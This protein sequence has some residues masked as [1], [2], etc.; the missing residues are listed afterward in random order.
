[1]KFTPEGGSVRIAGRSLHQA[2]VLS[3]TKNLRV[4]SES[5]FDRPLTENYLQISV[6]D[7]GIGLEKEDQVRIFDKFQ[8]VGD[9]SDHSTSQ[10]RFGGKGVGLGLALVKGI[11]E[12]HDGLAW[13]ESAGPSRGSCFSVLLPLADRHEGRYVLG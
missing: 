6:C 3:L 10:A 1:M 8:E 11:V 4:F 9:I 13:V 7:S 5:F 2:E 12:T